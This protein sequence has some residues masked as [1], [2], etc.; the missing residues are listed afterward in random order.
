M[1]KRDKIMMVILASVILLVVGWTV[2]PK[3]I[4]E[5]NVFDEMYYSRVHRIFD[6]FGVGGKNPRTMFSNMPQLEGVTRDNEMLYTQ[7]RNFYE[8]YKQEYLNANESL[9]ISMYVDRKKMYI[10]F[11]CED[12]DGYKWYVYCYYVEDRLLVYETNDPDNTERKNFL[13]EIFLPDWFAANEGI[14]HYSMEHLG[15]FEFVDKTIE[16][17]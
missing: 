9:H 12:I 10:D 11:S 8:N 17:E 6:W 13:Y 15:K 16:G 4:R 14:S 1:K 2:I 7:E 5:R 3:A